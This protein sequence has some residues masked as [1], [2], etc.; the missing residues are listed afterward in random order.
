MSD[1]AG[2][3]A[4]LVPVRCRDTLALLL[5]NSPWEVIPGANRRDLAIFSGQERERK[6]RGKMEKSW[7]RRPGKVD[8]RSGKGRGGG[9]RETP[10]MLPMLF[11]QRSAR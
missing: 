3:A 2:R 1:R 7:M 11:A 9:S 5:G 4:T 10:Q 6:S 8:G